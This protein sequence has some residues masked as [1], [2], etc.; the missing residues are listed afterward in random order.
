V[1]KAREEG[2]KATADDLEDLTSD[3]NFLNNLQSGVNKWINEIRKVT[4]LDR[5]L[6]SG[7]SIQETTFWTSIEKELNRINEMRESE[8]VVFTLEALKLG[9]RF[10]ATTAIDADTGESLYSYCLFGVSVVAFAIAS[11]RLLMP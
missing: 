4:K 10:H 3:S 2:R 7:T 8:E 6:T 11:E 9:K 5:D 1:A